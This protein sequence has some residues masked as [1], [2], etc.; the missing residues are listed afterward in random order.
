METKETTVTERLAAQRILPSSDIPPHQFLFCWHSI[1]CFARG[2]LV[3]VTG[4]AKSGKTYLNSIL[5]AVAGIDS[6]NRL[7]INSSFSGL[8]QRNPSFKV[9]PFEKGPGGFGNR[10]LGLTR[11]RDK[12][13]F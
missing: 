4:K 7:A 13:I 11:S 8:P 2:E 5:M 9:S 10:T 6:D 3:A 12:T 1:P